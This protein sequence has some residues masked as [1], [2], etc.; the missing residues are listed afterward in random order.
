[1]SIC[2]ISDVT[3]TCIEG[4]M[5]KKSTLNKGSVMNVKGCEY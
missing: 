4:G 3:V 2:G 5:N 1:M